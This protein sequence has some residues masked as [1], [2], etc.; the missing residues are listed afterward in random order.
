[1]FCM[2]RDTP[3]YNLIFNKN[4]LKYFSIKEYAHS[5]NIE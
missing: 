1:M 2:S 3:A 4:I 5:F